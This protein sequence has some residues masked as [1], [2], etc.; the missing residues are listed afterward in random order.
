MRSEMMKLSVLLAALTLTLA[1]CDENKGMATAAGPL[2]A[3]VN[4]DAITVQVIEKE[5]EKAGVKNAAESQEVANRVLN[6]LLEQRL[7]V[8][9]AKKT[10]LEKDPEVARALQ[11]AERQVLAQA[12]IEK[13]GANAA[14][15]GDTEIAA[16]YDAHPELFAE[17]RIYRLQEIMIQ[18]G[19]DSAEAVKARLS[20]GANLN[21][22]AQ[23][24]KSQNIPARGAQSVK[25]AE[26]LPMDLLAKLHPLK[27]GQAITLENPRQLT[28]LVLTGSQSQPLSREVARPAIERYL[29]TAKKRELAKVELE[30]LRAAAKIEYV[31]PY[32]ELKA[33]SAAHAL[34]A[35]KDEAA[36]GVFEKALSGAK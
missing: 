31:A 26:Q 17:R 10:G 36:Q 5:L 7:F 6:V 21:D 30:K 27:D 28:L 32:A 13:L 11:A 15:A 9:Q 16:Y 33:G 34:S 2:A 25:S 24:L 29:L 14:K 8:Q 19:P 1:G 22:L 35:P 12:Y 4:G 20:S 3:K 18:V 23:W